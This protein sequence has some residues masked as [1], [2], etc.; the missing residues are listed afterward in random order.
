MTLFAGSISFPDFLREHALA[1]SFGV[2][3]L[4]VPVPQQ[5]PA[6]TMPVQGQPMQ[7]MPIMQSVPVQSMPVAMQSVPT[8]PMQSAPTAPMQ[9][10]I[11]MQSV[12]TAPMQ[13]TAPMHQQIPMQPM[14]AAPMQQQIPM[15]AGPVPPWRATP[16]LAPAASKAGGA[17]GD[18][19]DDDWKNAWW[20]PDQGW[21]NWNTGGKKTHGDGDGDGK[22]T[23]AK[24]GDGYSKKSDK[25]GDGS[26]QN[27][28]KD[29]D[30]H[31]DGNGGD[32]DGQGPSSWKAKPWSK[33]A[34]PYARCN[35][36]RKVTFV[37]RTSPIRTSVVQHCR[38]RRCVRN[39]GKDKGQ[40]Q[41]CV[42]KK[43]NG[44]FIGKQ[45]PFLLVR[46]LEG[47]QILG[48]KVPGKFWENSW[49]KNKFMRNSWDKI[50]Q[51]YSGYHH[52]RL[53]R[54]ASPLILGGR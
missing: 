47:I 17:A 31:G 26:G 16:A 24:D 43:I 25:H 36:C 19:Q 54:M 18:R 33:Q 46:L 52:S 35:V 49:K 29:G 39:G 51:F 7:A 44:K 30:G 42:W 38:N 27:T 34:S 53:E 12:P 3:S 32:G 21:V 8:A 40:L 48:N 37:Y 45:T 50:H 10:Q 20:H 22:K 14:A 13:P 15:Q 5:V 11:P 23:A 6:Q 2:G 4:Q 9:Q 28:G 41:D 1:A